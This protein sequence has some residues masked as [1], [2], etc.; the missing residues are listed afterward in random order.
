MGVKFKVTEDV[1]LSNQFGPDTVLK[2]GV[3]EATEENR[4]ALERLAEQG[5]AERVKSAPD[6]EA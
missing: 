3:H 1:S 6:K 4:E 2:A 5:F